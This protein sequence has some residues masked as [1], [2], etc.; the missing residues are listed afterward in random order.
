MSNTFIY[1]TYIIHYN[2]DKLPP[3]NNHNITP[4]NY[5]GSTSLKS[6][7]AGYLG[8]VSSKKYKYIWNEEIKNNRNLFD[9]QII[10]LHNT[11]EEALIK[12]LE[13]Q[14]I[15]TVVLNPLFVN[16]S[17]AQKYGCHGR[18]VCGENNPRFGKGLKGVNNPRYGIHDDFET[19]NKISASLKGKVSCKDNDGNKISVTKD[20]YKNNPNLSANRKNKLSITHYLTKQK[21]DIPAEDYIKYKEADWAWHCTSCKYIYHTPFG[22]FFNITE[23][24]YK[25]NKTFMSSWC[26]NPDKIITKNSLTSVNNRDYILNCIGKTPRELGYWKENI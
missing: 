22:I 18:D 14:K 11:R 3:K 12:E 17:Y 23:A 13:L 10:S 24:G 5:I 21:L 8:S 9:I 15:F 25:F 6:I 20:E 16:M 2:G 26:N 19:Y 4:K 7:E 1:A